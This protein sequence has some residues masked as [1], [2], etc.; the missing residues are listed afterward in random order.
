MENTRACMCTDKKLE[1]NRLRHSFSYLDLAPYATRRPQ[2]DGA[3]QGAQQAQHAQ[4]ARLQ[5]K[6]LVKVKQTNDS[7]VPLR[8]MGGSEMG[9]ELGR[10]W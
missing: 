5:I 4:E 6:E 7:P 3:Q 2:K 8:R 9:G 10:W 1:V